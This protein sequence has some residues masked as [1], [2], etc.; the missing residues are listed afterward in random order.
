ML[1]K[2][3]CH[4]GKVAF[5]VD[6]DVTTVMECNCSHCSRKGFLLWFVPRTQFRLIKGEPS[7]GNYTFNKHQIQHKFC[8]HCGTQAFAMGKMPDGSEMA[9]INVR[10]LP[11]LDRSKLKV[12]Q[13]DGRKF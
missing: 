5:E 12:Q 3:S 8:S 11:E 6:G 2:G 1:H 13:V 4:C 9:A 10:C 7:L